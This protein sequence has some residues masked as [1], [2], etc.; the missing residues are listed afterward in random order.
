MSTISVAFRF[1]VNFYHSYRGDSLDER[2]IGK[3]IRIIRSIIESL[4]RLNAEG[5]PVAGTWDAENL[6]TLEHSIPEHAPDILEALRRRVGGGADEIEIMSYNNGLIPAHTR[7]EAREAIDRAV[8]NNA[9]SGVADLFPRY[10]TI[11]RPQ[12]MMYTPP[13]IGLLNALGVEALSLYYSSVPFNTFGSF[14]PALPVADRFNPMLLTTSATDERIPLIP[15]INHGDLADSLTL[16]RLV[17]RLRRSQA[18]GG[19][20]RDRRTDLLVLIDMDA[21][22]EF[23]TGLRVPVAG[24]LLS[25]ARGFEAI[26]RSVADLPY[27]RFTTPGTYLDT[28]PPRR[29]ITIDMDTADG[30][31]DGYASW[32][33]KWENHQLYASLDRSRRCSWAC[34][35]RWKA[36]TVD[37]R[38]RAL[39]TTHFGLAAPVMNVSRLRAAE[40]LVAAAADAATDRLRRTRPPARLSLYAG[41]ATIP[42]EYGVYPLAGAH[43]EVDPQVAGL[44]RSAR[45]PRPALRF[46]AIPGSDSRYSDSPGSVEPVRAVWD[47][48]E[49]RPGV[50]VPD[51]E[52]TASAGGRRAVIVDSTA[53]SPE[54]ETALL[55]F[56]PD[57]PAGCGRLTA[58]RCGA[59]RIAGSPLISGSL[60]YG[61]RHHGE[62]VEA[63]ST[64]SADGGIN[65][66]SVV[67]TL[68][69]R[70]ARIERRFV[71]AHGL[72]G[73]FVETLASIPDLP[74]HGVSREAEA[75]LER[76]YDDRLRELRPAEIVPDLLADLRDGFLVWRQSYL[77]PPVSFRLPYPGTPNTRLDSSNNAVC[78]SWIAV[79]DGSRGILVAQA[80]FAARS[81]A[82]CPL[83]VRRS[84]RGYTVA[85]N[86]FGTY[87]GRQ[88]RSPIAETGLGRLASLLTA[89]HLKPLAPSYA[90]RTHHFGLFI[91]PFEGDR[92]PEEL[93]QAAWLFSHPPEFIAKQD[94]QTDG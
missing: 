17:R 30:S 1:H 58:I 71:T 37:L 49:S 94:L 51:W 91:A 29:T 59:A 32:A 33:E 74:P 83:R 41:W 87:W 66:T 78:Q 31:F 64:V 40:E 90:G 16:G 2:G 3:D 77:G 15:A 14:I 55:T 18:R 46:L 5:I 11:M 26:V 45:T 27:L 22:D 54:Q 24:R 42:R 79:S 68:C 44:L 39:S 57:G 92:P 61:G 69:F 76:A 72:S 25:T 70:G 65:V 36:D 82:F 12:E 10:R 88:L 13:M 52:A 34:G 85:L 35:D 81:F 8:H 86:P 43:D 4:D 48:R 7:G 38:L 89:D 19:P 23:W 84:R 63:G 62:R 21:D 67:S 6:F 50:T 28:H 53:D 56:E 20:R 60:T 9:G 73:V 93:R 47:G 75:R 80:P